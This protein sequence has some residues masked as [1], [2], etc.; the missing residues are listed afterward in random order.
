MKENRPK[1]NV[2]VYSYNYWND[3]DTPHSGVAII[4]LFDAVVKNQSKTGNKPI[5]VVCRYV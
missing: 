5:T 2:S 3:C 4:N 1:L